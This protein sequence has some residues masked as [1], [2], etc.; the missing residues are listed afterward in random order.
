M[1]LDEAEVFLQERS[2]QDLQRNALV[3]GAFRNRHVG[4]LNTD[5]FLAVF[6]R[7]LEYY[8]GT[9]SFDIR[10]MCKKF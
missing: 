8:D 5:H 1:L 9:H 7:V 4:Y 2:L 3:S 6:L 10:T